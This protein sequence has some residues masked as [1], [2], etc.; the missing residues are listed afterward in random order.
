MPLKI[1][2]CGLS[3]EEDIALSA[4]L[5]ASYLGLIRYFQSPRYVDDSHARNLIRLI[6]EG[7]RVAVD[8]QPDRQRISQFIN[9]GFDWFQ[10]HFTL[11]TPQSTI[12]SW[13]DLA[14]P[15]RL[16]LAPKLPPEIEEFPP[17]L[18]NLANTFLIDTYATNAF[19]G[20]GKT[21]NWHR[22]ASWQKQYPDKRWIL[23]GGLN[24]ENIQEAL[25]SSGAQHIDVNSGA[26]SSPGRKDATKLR[27]FFARATS[28]NLT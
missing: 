13:S 21:G 7:R 25:T 17:T 6:P 4:S 16:W 24:P 22:F 9:E 5:G 12:L 15:A 1:K 28:V 10:I 26:E 19:G 3:R 18:L 27:Q 20:T 11:N 23:A 8:V 14:S 2:V